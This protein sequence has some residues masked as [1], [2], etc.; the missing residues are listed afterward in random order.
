MGIMAV[1]PTL[2]PCH[3]MH[4]LG[5]DGPVN[6]LRQAFVKG[7]VPQSWIFSGM[8]GIG[9]ATFAYQMAREILKKTD[10]DARFIDRQIDAGTYPNLMVVSCGVDE[11]G[12][13]N[14]DITVDDVRKI[15]TSLHQSAAIPGWR[16]VLIDA[17]DDL[18]RNAA[19]AV[20]KVLEEPPSQTLFFLIA[21]SMGRL[22]PTIRS[23]CCHL[24]FSP[25]PLEK[26]RMTVE[27]M[28][29]GDPSVALAAAQGSLG[30]YTQFM[31]ADSHQLFGQVLAILPSILQ[32]D[33]VK[34]QA[35]SGTFVKADP[36]FPVALELIA[37]ILSQLTLLAH[38][39]SVG[40][41]AA[42][43][44]LPEMMQIQTQLRPLVSLV[45]PY[46]WMQ[47]Y[48]QVSHFLSQAHHAHL[49][50]NHVMMAVFF[51]INNPELGEKF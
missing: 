17:A 38:D 9:K 44:I 39:S 15:T 10:Y 3:Q 51:M 27:K 37:W 26:M 40:N 36:R 31:A 13:K 24:T 21:H 6:V 18:N 42:A 47:A 32:G 50:Q 14:R 25:L 34:A 41:K 11:D 45:S 43:E 7:K 29:G 8:R 46:H 23:R 16:I 22:L 5:H 49:D 20:L 19:N 30:R 48:Q 1:D 33:F 12:K 4:L 2:P 28:G 35:F